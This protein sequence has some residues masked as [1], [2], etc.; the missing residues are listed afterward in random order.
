[1]VDK[2]QYDHA[3][4]DNAKYDIANLEFQKVLAQLKKQKLLNFTDFLR[5]LKK[6]P[7]PHKITF[8]GSPEVTFG[9]AN[10]KFGVYS[11]YF[12]KTKKALE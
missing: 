10:I 11:N 3:H 1:M 6:V 12:E 2:A 5:Q 4:W 9:Q 8:G 7:Q